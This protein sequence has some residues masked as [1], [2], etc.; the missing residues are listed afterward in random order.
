MSQQPDLNIPRKSPVQ[1]RSI[2]T[3]DA[4]LDATIQVLL[5][6][7]I[8]RC[9]TTRVAERAGVSVGTLYQ[10][11]PNRETLLTAVLV[12]HL[13]GVADDVDEACVACHHLSL[14]EMA[15]GL[16]AGWL[17]SKLGDPV[18]SRALYAIAENYAAPE[19]IKPPQKRVLMSVS[20]MLET[21]SDGRFKALS[22]VSLMT[23]GAIYGPVRL[24][25][26]GR[27][28]LEDK[29]A[30]RL[31]LVALTRAYLH[32]AANPIE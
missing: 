23:L 1:A 21:A 5:R 24:F 10:Y 12:R 15:Q 4:V 28:E 6:E 22:M 27:F 32:Q 11:Y 7:G 31:Q 9:T 16:V 8:D 26:E 19:V 17:K 3:V 18:L 2:A 30:F 14:D 25:L 13:H 29:D 20:A